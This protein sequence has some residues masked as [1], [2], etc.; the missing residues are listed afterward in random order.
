MTTSVMIPAPS[1]SATTPAGR[2]LT[3]CLVLG[4]LGFL[5]L[6]TSYAARGWWD[7]WT[8][9]AHILAA[10]VYGLTALALVGLTRGRLQAVLLVIAVI[11]IVGNA[12]VGDD[13]LHVG[14]GGNDLFDEQGP[15]NLWK[16][17]GFFF[18][19]TFL[20]GAL[21]L[22]RRTPLWWA[23]L[24]VAGAVVF[25][26]AHVANISWLAILDG[27]LMLAALGSLPRV[28]RAE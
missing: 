7:A 28:L 21:A 6:D 20:L 22:R 24:L 2:L 25:P 15:A 12:G 11:G 19:L 10:A 8:G 13:T 27:V 23:P 26:I 5:A 18:P 17:L 1:A 3:V 9:M 4:P 16:M 14:L